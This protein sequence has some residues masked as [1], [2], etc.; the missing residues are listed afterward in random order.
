[1]RQLVV[2]QADR[3]PAE[4]VEDLVE[5]VGVDR[6]GQAVADRGGPD[7]DPGGG[8]PGVGGRVV[9]QLVGEEDG[10]RPGGPGR[11]RLRRVAATP[12]QPSSDAC[13]S[14]SNVSS[15][16]ASSTTR[17]V[18][19]QEVEERR[20]QRRLADVLRLRRDDDRDAGLDE[21][22]ERRGELRIEHARPDQLDDRAR[23][24]RDGPERPAALRARDVGHDRS[25]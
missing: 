2:G 18:R 7:R 23:L 10:R 20:E 5:R 17:L 24:G 15:S 25:L 16:P 6:R 3:R 21:Q 4:H 19:R 9:G 13:G 1:M 12:G 22:P 14:Q 8:A 11:C